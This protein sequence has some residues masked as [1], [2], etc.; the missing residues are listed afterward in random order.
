MRVFESTC[1]SNFSLYFCHFWRL[2]SGLCGCF[3]RYSFLQIQRYIHYLSSS[4]SIILI[5]CHSSCLYAFKSTIDPLLSRFLCSIFVFNPLLFSNNY[6]FNNIVAEFSAF[7]CTW[8]HQISLFRTKFSW[9]VNLIVYVHLWLIIAIYWLVSIHS[10]DLLNDCALTG[11]SLR[12]S[13]MHTL[14]SQSLKGL[15]TTW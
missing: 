2:L 5:D 8:A 10:G 4:Y 1:M 7:V 9:L 12:H 11:M 13:M 3:I 15:S 14:S 6:T